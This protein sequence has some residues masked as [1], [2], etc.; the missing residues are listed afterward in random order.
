MPPRYT[1]WTILVD[2]LPTA[3][4]SARREELR[5][6]FERLRAKHPNAVMRWF[7]RGRLWNSPEE[8]EAPLAEA[9]ATVELK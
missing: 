8:A 6:T 3:F 2:D 5:P 7:A 9:G 4:R 1:Y